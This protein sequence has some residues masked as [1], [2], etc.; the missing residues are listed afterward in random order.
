[1]TTPNDLSIVIRNALQRKKLLQAE[2][3]GWMQKIAAAQAEMNANLQA[4]ARI[5]VMIKEIQASM[6][7][8]QAL[9]PS[10]PSSAGQEA[11]GGTG[12]TRAGFGNSQA[13]F[14]QIAREAI[15]QNGRPM[16]TSEILKAF[17]ERGYPIEGNN[18]WKIASNNLWKAKADGRF[19][20]KVGVGYWPADVPNVALSYVPPPEGA[21]P[22]K[23]RPPKL[24]NRQSRSTG[25]PPGRSKALTPEQ[26]QLAKKWWGEGK[27]GVDIARELGGVSMGTIYRY[28]REAGVPARQKASGGGR[29]KKQTGA[30]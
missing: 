19:I 12:L 3:Q 2:V 18:P 22:L 29:K 4:I 13:F 14:E 30:K 21:T 11:T 10:E 16:Q 8:V 26:I 28:L 7:D 1:M 24:E 6:P 25:R 27:T 23:L 20:H 9:S 15:L 5:D 17:Q